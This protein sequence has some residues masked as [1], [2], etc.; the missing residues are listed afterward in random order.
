LLLRVF[1]ARAAKTDMPQE[2]TTIPH[3]PSERESVIEAAR[4]SEGKS[5]KQRVA[6]F[7]DL[8]ETVD[9]LWRDLSPEERRRRLDI[10][11]QLD[12]KPEPWWKNL[13]PEAQPKPPCDV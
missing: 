8:L 9:V 10:A 7:I 3:V 5:P 2:S 13:R 6:M 1:L 4:S 12:P 11:R